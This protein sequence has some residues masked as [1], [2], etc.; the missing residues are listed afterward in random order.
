VGLLLAGDLAGAHVASKHGWHHT[1]E[2]PGYETRFAKAAGAFRT[3]VRAA[4]YL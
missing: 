2:H 1:F 4:G 3:V